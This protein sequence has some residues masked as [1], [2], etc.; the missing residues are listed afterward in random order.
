M[1]AEEDE[2]VGVARLRCLKRQRLRRVPAR[3]HAGNTHAAGEVAIGKAHPRAAE[4]ALIELL[5]TKARLE[6]HAPERGAHRPAALPPRPRR[7]PDRPHR[8]PAA[9]LD[10]APDRTPPPNADR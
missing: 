4:A 8:P 9:G 10:G 6:R 5:E 1:P 3:A 7:P 2:S